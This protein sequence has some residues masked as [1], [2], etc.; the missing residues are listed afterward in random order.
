M[1]FILLG[2]ILIGVASGS[3]LIGIGVLLLALG[4]AAPA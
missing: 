3:W 2:S 4:M 1:L